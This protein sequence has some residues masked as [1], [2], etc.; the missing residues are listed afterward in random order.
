MYKFGYANL[1]KKDNFS[2]FKLSQEAFELRNPYA[3]YSLA[4]FY[5][6]GI[7]IDKDIDKAIQLHKLAI[8]LGSTESTYAL[9]VAHHYGH[10]VE[11]SREIAIEYY[12]KAIE[13][14]NHHAMVN[15]AYLYLQDGNAE[16]ALPLLN[17]VSK[18]QDSTA[19]EEANS[20]LGQL[21]FHGDLVV[22]N[23]NTA[24]NHFNNS[25]N[26]SDTFARL[27]YLYYFGLGTECNYKLSKMYLEQ[28]LKNNTDAYSEFLLGWIFLYGQD[29]AVDFRKAI[30]YLEI[31]AKNKQKDAIFLLSKFFLG[32]FDVAHKDLVQSLKWLY[33]AA[34]IGFNEA[35][36]KMNSIK[37]KISSEGI[38][39]AKNDAKFI[40]SVE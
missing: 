30:Y 18:I 9:G 4:T 11:V 31:S 37:E 2:A 26:Y 22:Q 39:K 10:G 35:Y 16:E 24:F 13:K 32:E 38:E 12:L 28:Y 8:D 6:E 14:E 7:A 5:F 1:L 3:T 20:T 21:Y 36:E 15:L 29:T 19:F 17:H 27:G 23:Y 40:L 25:R 33:F 34:D